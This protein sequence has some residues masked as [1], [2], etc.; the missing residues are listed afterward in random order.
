[1]TFVW[2]LSLGMFRSFWKCGVVSEPLFRIFRL[3]IFHLISFD[4]DLLFRRNFRVGA[5]A[6]ELVLGIFRL[7]PFA[8]ELSFGVLRVCEL[9]FRSFRLGSSFEV[10]P[11]GA[12][13]WK[14]SLGNLRL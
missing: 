7:G 2:E 9:W 3:E 12:L 13:T 1:M 11:W 14:L 6:Q 10:S 4:W 5:F 8:L